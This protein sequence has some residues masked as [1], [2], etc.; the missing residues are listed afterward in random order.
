MRR[1]LLAVTTA[2]PCLYEHHDPA[3]GRCPHPHLARLVQPRH[4]SSIERTARAGIPWAADN[5][6]YSGWSAASAARFEAMLERLAGLPAC[7]FVTAPDFPGDHERTAMFYEEGASLI[8]RHRLPA[9]FVVQDGIESPREV[10]WGACDAVFIGGQLDEFRFSELVRAILRIAKRSGKWTHFGRVNSRR[11][12]DYLAATGAVD[13][14]D[15]SSYARY[16]D[17][18]LN[19]ALAW[20]AEAAARPHLFH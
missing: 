10:P 5:D 17:A 18:R 12:L 7:L 19:Q 9:A 16:R 11:R 2:H 15:G 1:P 4:Y 8:Y 3:T 13:S 6:A 20:C 14:F